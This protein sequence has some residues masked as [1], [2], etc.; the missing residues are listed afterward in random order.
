M[1]AGLGQASPA[2]R[3]V[4]KVF[5]LSAEQLDRLSGAFGHR[6]RLPG[7]GDDLDNLWFYDSG[8]ETWM[9]TTSKIYPYLYSARSKNWLYFWSRH[10]RRSKRLYYDFSTNDTLSIEE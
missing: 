2:A 3:E 8:T 6:R 9:W 1:G 10:S 7:G 5:G 4:G